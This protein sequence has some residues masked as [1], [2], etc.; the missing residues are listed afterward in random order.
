[1][2]IKAKCVGFKKSET[3]KGYTTFQGYF[4]VSDEEIEKFPFTKKGEVIGN[5]TLT[6]FAWD[7]EAKNFY[8]TLY[9]KKLLGK[10]VTLLG[11]FIKNDFNCC[12]IS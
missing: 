12:L 4:I 7:T 3:K 1:M 5:M 2:E 10:D 9:E 11:S 6:I 8:S